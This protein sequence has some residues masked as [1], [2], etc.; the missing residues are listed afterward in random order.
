MN[1]GALANPV[2]RP[3]TLVEAFRR[4]SVLI[5]IIA[6][7][8][9]R[10]AF[11][12]HGRLPF[13]SDEAIVG[14]M[15][16]HILYQGERPLFYYGQSYLGPLEPVSAAISFALFGPSV[17]SLRL[18]PTL[19]SLLFIFFSERVARRAFGDAAAAATSIYLAICPLFLLTWSVKARGGY[20]ELVT[21][22]SAILWLSL[23][24]DGS[25]TN[26]SWSWP[27]L[28]AVAGLAV[29]TDPLAVVYL[30]PTVFY[31]VIRLQ[32][33]LW[34]WGPVQAVA[35]FV[36]TSWPMLLSN[37]Y[38]HG[39]TL[40]QLVN[41]NVSQPISVATLRHN[42]SA[43][44]QNSLPILLGFFQASSNLPAFAAVRAQVPWLASIATVV[45]LACAVGA[46]ILFGLSIVRAAQTR[47]EPRDLLVWVGACTVALFCISQVEVLYVTEPRYLLPLYSLVPLAGAYWGRLWARH[48]SIA[49]S[50]ILIVLALNVAS[51]LGFAPDLAAPRLDGK[52][53][54][55][56][57]P[58]L[59]EF[60]EARQ[61]H[62]VYTDYWLS[63]PIAFQSQ[64]R[65][66]P[67]VIDANLR[68][69]F[70]RYVPYATTVE[71]DPAPAV[72]VVAGSPSEKRLQ[73]F[74]QESGRAY[75]VARWN[76]LDL[77]DRITPPFR[78]RT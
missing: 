55:A 19:Y 9:L 71:R 70:N 68:V 54:D 34:S 78:P 60:L 56:G 2:G 40:E 10:F 49:A 8:L 57:D 25:K 16:R 42:L 13:E 24:L 28:G 76:N 23:D 74:L 61:I 4:R 59:A 58:G 14:L 77:F 38:S 18:A 62:A 47:P 73:A 66:V 3:G 6:G 31:L 53:V 29:W 37:V 44:V 63:Y 52:V 45:G 5:A 67:S 32:M 51:I 35:G 36:L 48:R 75:D 33:R 7:A 22:G 11:I 41:P 43:V 27:L 30:V 72:L 20:A 64:E 21:L 1:I 17:V 39:A 46:T 69:G 26:H 65:I 12:L 15:A 50:L